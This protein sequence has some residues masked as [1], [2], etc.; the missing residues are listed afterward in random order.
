MTL[1]NDWFNTKYRHY[2]NAKFSFPV[3]DPNDAFRPVPRDFNYAEVFRG[4]YPRQIRNDVFSLENSLYTPVTEDGEPVHFNQKSSIMV[5]VDAVTE[6]I[7]IERYGKHY[8]CMKVG[9]RKHDPIFDVENEKEKVQRFA[10]ENGL[11]IIGEIERSNAIN[12]YE[13]QGMTVIE[14]DPDLPVSRC[15]MELAGKLLGE[16]ESI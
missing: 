2:L 10:D 9:E 7:Y 11:S 3:K 1:L 5:Y 8:T 16:Q 15:F 6:E 4:E 13:D 14:G 12:S